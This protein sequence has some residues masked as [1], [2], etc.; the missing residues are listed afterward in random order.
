[1]KTS[2]V[3]SLLCAGVLAIAT[4]SSCCSSTQVVGISSNS[5]VGE[6]VGTA[7]Q[8]TILGTFGIGGPRQ[9]IANA[10]ADARIKTISHV[11]EFNKSYCFGIVT[12]HTIRVYGE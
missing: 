10:A 4:M 5:P 7:T 9:S 3:L 2:K 8:V 1:M 12:R 11:E 6:K